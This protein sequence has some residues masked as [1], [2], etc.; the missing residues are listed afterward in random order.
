MADRAP[1]ASLTPEQIRERAAEFR[2]M[3]ATASTAQIRDALIRLA[4]RLEA[5]ATVREAIE[6]C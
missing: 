3:A 2:R 6:R 1:L 5:L 4:E